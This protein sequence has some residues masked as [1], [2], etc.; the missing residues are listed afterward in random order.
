MTVP[1]SILIHAL[2]CKEIPQLR[3]YLYLKSMASGH[4]KITENVP[5]QVCEAMKWKDL[6]TY[7]TNLEWLLKHHWASFNNKSQSLRIVSFKQLHRR[8]HGSV[9]TGVRMNIEDFKNFRAFIYAA[10]ISWGM[11]AKRKS[12]GKS[13]CK[14]GSFGKGLPYSHFKDL[15]ETYLAEILHLDHSTISRYKQDARKAGYIKIH[16]QFLY[17]HHSSSQISL[18]RKY[19]DEDEA[20]KLVTHNN[21]AYLQQC[22]IMKGFVGLAYLKRL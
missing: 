2:R 1:I 21:R 4:L 18:M 14:R 8:F 22:D 12:D 3:L 10:V 16:H 13:K 19:M 17:L 7:K 9:R 15:P 11:S 20:K 5:R 6:R